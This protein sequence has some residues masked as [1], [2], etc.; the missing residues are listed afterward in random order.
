M[1][2]SSSDVV[3]GWISANPYWK[4][5][6][7]IWTRVHTIYWPGSKNEL[8]K[9]VRLVVSHQHPTNSHELEGGKNECESGVRIVHLGKNVESAFT[10]LCQGSWTNER[11]KTIVLKPQLSAALKKEICE[12]AI[13]EVQVCTSCP[14]PNFGKIH[15]MFIATLPPKNPLDTKKVV[16]GAVIHNCNCCDRQTST[17]TTNT[18]L[19]PSRLCSGF[20]FSGI[21]PQA[22]FKWW[23]VVLIL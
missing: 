9:E 11:E 21:T 5:T 17:T 20:L 12:P 18:D 10:I 15:S 2:S 8:L 16:N 14:A 19:A 6:N 13:W 4:V 7:M 3:N 23:T 1:S 22:H